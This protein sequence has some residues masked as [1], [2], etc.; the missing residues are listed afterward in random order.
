M[1]SFELSGVSLEA[2]Q[3]QAEADARAISRPAREVYRTAAVLKSM[4]V[5]SVGISAA[6]AFVPGPLFHLLSAVVILAGW[7]LAYVTS[8]PRGRVFAILFCRLGPG[9][10][11]PGAGGPEQM[12]HI[13]TLVMS[14][15]RYD[16]LVQ[17]WEAHKESSAAAWGAAAGEQ[18]LEVLS[19]AYPCLPG[20]ATA[21]APPGGDTLPE[22]RLVTMDPRINTPARYTARVHAEAEAARARLR[23]VAAA[24]YYWLAAGL[25]TMA[26][27]VAWVEL[28]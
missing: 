2:R 3:A 8:R 14:R 28:F 17:Q 13:E 7:V 18:Y 9:A 26:A 19:L 1:A 16:A 5:M 6:W 25:G 10:N 12:A 23:A 4:A 21:A 11:P 20:D 24:G 15:A 22:W 27:L